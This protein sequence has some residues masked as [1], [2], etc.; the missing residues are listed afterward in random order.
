[1]NIT[2][3]DVLSKVNQGQSNQAGS[4]VSASA[5]A[6]QL[7]TS[8]VLNSLVTGQTI[9]GQIRSMQGSQIL[10]AMGNGVEIGARLAF[11]TELATDF[12]AC[13]QFA[14]DWLFGP[15]IPREKI[16]ILKNA[17]EL[18]RYR[19]N[20]EKRSHIRNKLGIEN[21]LVLGTAGRLSY[22]KNQMFLVELFKKFHREHPRSKLIILGDGELRD[23]L[24]EQI[25]RSGLE[26]AVLM[27]GWKTDIEVYFQ[28][29][30]IFLLPSRFEG[31]GIV[32]LEAAASGLPCI[33]SDQV[34]SDVAVSETVRRVPL[35]ISDWGRAL[36]EMIQVRIDRWQGAEIVRAAGYDV[37]QQAKVLESLYRA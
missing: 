5:I 7:Q 36:E 22:Q 24:N 4:A 6:K 32:A 10:L 30:D 19:F 3:T 25:H 8:A 20:A 12:W 14:A 31:L 28:A 21:A 15:Q 17:I 11:S 1:M 37:Q 13:S 9:G 27:L 34:P 33:V 23:D 35:S 2:L 29:M 16:R 18:E 26:Q